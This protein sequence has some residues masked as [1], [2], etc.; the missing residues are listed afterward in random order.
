[1]EAEKQKFMS[2]FEE[3]QQFLKQ[4][5]KSL[6]DQ[7]EAFVREEEK[8]ITKLSSEICVTDIVIHELEEKS[9]YPE[10]AFLKVSLVSLKMTAGKIQMGDFFCA[11]TL[12]PGVLWWGKQLYK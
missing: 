11:S 7:L 2:K 8:F 1:M 10:N 6:L 9:R 4:Q 3:V 12:M 5:E